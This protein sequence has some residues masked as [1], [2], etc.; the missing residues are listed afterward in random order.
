MA[1]ARPSRRQVLLSLGAGVFALAGCGREERPSPSAEAAPSAPPA[2]T[3]SAGPRV[4]VARSPQAVRDYR[5]REDVVGELLDAALRSFTGEDAASAWR[6]LFRPGDVVAIK[7]NCLGGP[8]LRSHP[9]LVEHIVRGL[10]GAGVALPDIIIYDRLSGELS[11]CGFEVR[12]G[13]AGPLC[14]GTDEVGYDAEP[15]V[16]RSVGSC[17]SRIVSAQCTAIINV[18]VL[19]DHDVAGLSGALKNHFGSI[20]NPNKLHLDHCTPYVADLNCADVLREKQRLIVYDGLLACYD[21]GPAFKPE[22]TTG[23]GAI[24]VATDPVAADAVAL[25]AVEGLRQEQGLAPLMT[26]ERQP[27]YLALAADAEHRLGTADLAKIN[28]LEAAV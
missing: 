1:G 25:S 12:T 28:V 23:Y 22:T 6:S 27:A 4:A 17:F 18:P 7:V 11:E 8:Q 3:M 19:K 13:G 16:V 2:G 21:G 20:H 9:E 24:M 26:S 5:V 10:A 15:T 14:Y